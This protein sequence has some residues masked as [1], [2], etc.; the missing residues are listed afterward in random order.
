MK[1][2]IITKKLADLKKHA[3]IR[4]STL[5]SVKSEK[6]SEIE[7]QNAIDLMPYVYKVISEAN[8]EFKAR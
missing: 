8:Y 2:E 3:N 5:P 1:N 6:D 4:K 7:N